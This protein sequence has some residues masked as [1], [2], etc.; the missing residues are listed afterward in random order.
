MLSEEAL[1]YGFY[2]KGLLPFHNYGDFCRQT[3]F[4][5]TFKR[6]FVVFGALMANAQLHFTISEQH[7]EM[8]LLEF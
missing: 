7:G 8:F 5:E 4:E 2:P 6:G 3:P 1:N